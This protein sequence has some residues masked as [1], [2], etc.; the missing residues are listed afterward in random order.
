ML[1]QLI[2]DL[3]HCMMSKLVPRKEALNRKPMSWWSDD[4]AR[5]QQEV[6]RLFAVQHHDL[7]KRNA[8]VEA[9]NKYKL[10]IESAKKVSWRNFCSKAESTK[11]ISTLMKIMEGANRLGRISIL[12]KTD[13]TG[14]VTPEASVKLLMETHFEGHTEEVQSDQP[15]EGQDSRKVDTTKVCEYV[16]ELKVA[17]AIQSFG[18]T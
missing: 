18:P 1:G 15:M 4:L 6:K 2:T 14:V 10:A 5:Q 3:L 9:R 13:G 8:Y 7:T 11:D 12:N 17:K 16:D